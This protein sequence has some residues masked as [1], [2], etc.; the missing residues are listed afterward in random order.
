VITTL[1]DK[2]PAPLR[3]FALYALCGGSGVALDFCVYAVLVSLGLWYQAA[4]IVGYAAGT[5]LSFVLNRAITFRVMDAPLRRLASF[6]AVAAIGYGVSSGALWL[7]IERMAFNQL[8]AKA[9]VL[10]LV[11]II[12]FGINSAVTFRSSKEGTA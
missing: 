1:L 5:L 8:L 12:Q 11:V 4:N 2:L 10:V 7:L 9:A 6:L 3:R